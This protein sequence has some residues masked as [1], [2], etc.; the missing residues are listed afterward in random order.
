MLSPFI[1]LLVFSPFQFIRIDFEIN[2]LIHNV[3]PFLHELV[4]NL[5]SLTMWCQV[6]SE[7]N[8]IAR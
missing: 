7:E 2:L 4:N 8:G 6:Y 1:I 3:F 5:H